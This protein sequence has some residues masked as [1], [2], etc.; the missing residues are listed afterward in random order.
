M[1]AVSVSDVEEGAGVPAVDSTISIIQ[2]TLPSHVL[3]K[4]PELS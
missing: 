1:A 2:S 3:I 4:L